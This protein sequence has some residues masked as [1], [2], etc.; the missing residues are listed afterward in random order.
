VTIWL[1]GLSA[2]TRFT[3]KGRAGNGRVARWVGL[4]SCGD[5]QL[6]AQDVR[7]RQERPGFFA[8]GSV[9]KPALPAKRRPLRFTRPFRPWFSNRW[10][11]VTFT[12]LLALV[13]ADRII[14]ASKITVNGL[15]W[16]IR[17]VFMSV[18]LPDVVEGARGEFAFQ[19]RRTVQTSLVILS[20]R[21][22]KRPGSHGVQWGDRIST[23]NPPDA[24]L[25]GDSSG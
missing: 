19:A 25:R 17:M 18:A 8:L 2:S 5:R 11:T 21:S 20:W 9:R 1:Y 23:W 6:S 16:P 4:R 3:V 13:R 22:A 10:D 7:L 12:P 14:P 24:R 15:A